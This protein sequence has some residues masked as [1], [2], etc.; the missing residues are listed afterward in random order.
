M[1][2]FN[3]RL[4]M[5]RKDDRLPVKFYKPLQ[6]TGPT[7]GVAMSREEIESALDEYY[8]LA[9]WDPATGNP[10]VET[11]ERLGIEFRF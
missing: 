9:G 11:L 2:V 7:A 5:G 1:R 4:G 10:R 3:A 6:G 8:R